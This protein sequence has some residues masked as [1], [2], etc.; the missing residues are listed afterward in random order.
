MRKLKEVLRLH[1]LGL[2]QQQIAGSCSISQ[3]TVHEYLK[4]ARLA[5]IAW[6]VPEEWDQQRLQQAL[7]S[8]PAGGSVQ[9]KNPSPDFAAMRNELQTH[10][11]LTLQLVWEEY[12]Q[13]Q[14][15][16]YAYSHF[17]ELYRAWLKKQDWVLRQDHRAGEKLFVD[18]AGD[19][20]P[21]WNPENSEVAFRAAIF[22]A[23]M[24]ASSYTFAEATESQELRCWIGSHLRAF[25][26]LGGVPEILVPDNTK[27]GVIKACRYEPD[28]N[29]TYRDMAEHY[30]VAVVPARPYKPRDKAKVEV[31]VQVVQ[32][33]IVA[34]VRKRK[35]F[36]L[37]ELNLAI[38]ELLVRVNRRPFRKRDGNR[39]SLFAQLDQPALRS[40]PVDRYEFG[41]WQRIRVNPDYHV[42]VDQHFY[43]VPYGLVRESVDVRV[44]ATTVEILHRGLRVTSHTRSFEANQATTIEEHRPK[45]HREY[46]AWTPSRILDYGRKVGPF[47]AEMVETILT[48][49]HP[50]VG[51][52]ACMGILS[53]AK[54]YS[55]ERLEAACAR[56]VHCR[57]FHYPS[58]K[59][60]LKN[61]LDRAPLPVRDQQR[62][63]AKHENIRGAGYFDG[64]S[65][66]Q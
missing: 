7:F 19:T 38:G 39:A 60:I 61:E 25:D 37:D 32:R 4:A 5:G 18:Y 50:D 1:S 14:P 31:G 26:F 11:N 65:T 15:G 51:F 47:T 13:S 22:V 54:T 16:G 42:E 35:F 23:A 58:V 33:W 56:A 8:A 30:G 40:L 17:C 46:L 27:T 10:R 57:A 55:E 3:S 63:A 24:G 9:R 49:R 59:S 12:R 2:K 66:I 20:I 36:S 48:Q 45:S 64:P 6:P 41:T 62:P 29:P 28:L 34:A 52:R 44:T 43:S 21:I 53:L